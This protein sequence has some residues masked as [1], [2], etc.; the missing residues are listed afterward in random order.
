MQL[1][2]LVSH[3]VCLLTAS[4]P[5]RSR[6]VEAR[7]MSKRW[8]VSAV[9]AA[10]KLAWERGEL[11]YLNRSQHWNRE[12]RTFGATAALFPQFE[13]DGDR[14]RAAELLI[15]AYFD[16]YGPASVRDAVWWSGLSQAQVLA[17]LHNSDRPVTGV[18]TRWST[19][20]LYMY[21]D[22]IATDA[23]DYTSSTV[24]FLAHEDVALKAYFETRGRYMGPWPR[25]QAFNQIGEV[26][27]TVLLDGQVIGCW[28]WNKLDRRV[29]WQAFGRISRTERRHCQ[30]RAAT[31]TAVLRSRY[32]HG[33]VSRRIRP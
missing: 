23:D 32:D 21:T 11:A 14:S 7:V 9:R 5:L 31:L 27:P 26:L 19:S 6:E 12:D 3:L 25:Q 20:L 8:P 17:A 13:Q 22:C 4:G 15:Q 10:L 33:A 24:D 16:R 30:D 1:G 18:K 29:T 2:A 28:A